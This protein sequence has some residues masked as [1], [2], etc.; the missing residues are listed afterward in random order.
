MEVFFHNLEIARLADRHI[1]LNELRKKECEKVPKGKRKGPYVSWWSA[2][3]DHN[4]DIA[5]AVMFLDLYD[6]VSPQDHAYI[7]PQAVRM[8]GEDILPYKRIYEIYYSLLLSDCKTFDPLAYVW[9]L[10]NLRRYMLS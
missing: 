1:R 3:G 5:G 6:F 4:M 7:I 8:Y 10:K 2:V 9:S